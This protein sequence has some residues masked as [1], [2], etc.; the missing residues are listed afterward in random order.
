MCK[1]KIEKI[2]LW[3]H[4]ILIDE[5]YK[6]KNVKCKQMED[7]GFKD[8]FLALNSKSVLRSYVLQYKQKSMIFPTILHP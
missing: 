2:I 3:L 6:E 8:E 5:N 1:P 7:K 4:N